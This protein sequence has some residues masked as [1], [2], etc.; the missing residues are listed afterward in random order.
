M[1]TLFTSK[2][3]LH[4]R[5]K[6]VKYYV[7]GMALYGAE[8]W[9]LRIV[10]QKYLESFEIWCRKRIEINPTEYVEYEEVLQRIKDERNILH[11]IQRKKAKWLGHN[12]R[13]NCPQKHVIEVNVEGTGR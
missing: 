1:K 8:T 13:R 7:W 10:G 11:T 6:L 2:L 9:A 12:L 4:L 5:K 3:D